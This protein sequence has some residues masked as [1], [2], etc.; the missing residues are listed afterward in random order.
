MQV[1]FYHFGSTFALRHGMPLAL[2]DVMRGQR[3]AL[4]VFFVLSGFVLAYT[5][6][7]QMGAKGSIRRFAEARFARIYPLYVLSLVL[8]YPFRRPDALRMLVCLGM[9]QAWNPLRPDLYEAW[10]FTAWTLSV[11]MFFYLIFPF[12]LVRL[13]HLRLRWLH[14]LMALL[15]FIMVFAHTSAYSADLTGAWLIA[16]AKWTPLPLWRLPEFML[17]VVL[18]LMFLRSPKRPA[19]RWALYSAIAA[20]LLMLAYIHGQWASLLMIPDAVIVYELAHEGSAV[21]RFL[22]TK[23]LLLLGG[24]SYAMYLLQFPVRRVTEMGF[25]HISAAMAS[26]GPA[27]VSPLLLIGLAVV[28]HLYFE[29]PVRRSLRK[30]FA[31]S[32]PAC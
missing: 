3:N 22:S 13:T 1:I 17:G 2:V 7:G 20:A 15:L 27:L 30:W 14:G 25:A 8:S 21:G 32:R 18:G 10:N 26:A 11:E 28:V 24:A 29:E 31:R 9:V 6:T 12:M 23:L 19:R 5:Y 4:S 16:I